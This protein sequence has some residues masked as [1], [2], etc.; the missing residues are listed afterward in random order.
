MSNAK[1]TAGATV[2]AGMVAAPKA[3]EGVRA[4]GSFLVEC[5]DKDGNLKW[6]HEEHNLVVNIGLKLMN[7]SF[8]AGAA[9]TASFFIGLYGAAASNNPAPGDTM[10]SHVGWIEVTSYSNATRPGV[11]FGAAT[12]ASPS[13]ISNAGAPAV[14]NINNTAVIGGAFLTTDNTKGGTAGLLFSAADFTGVGD[15]NVD[16]GDILNVT[17][18]FSLLAA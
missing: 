16:N 4:G 17:Y 8:F 14:F 13:V 7:D 1:A 10:A 3:A 15:R 11:T 12:T 9:Y 18:T 5:R 2:S 6:V